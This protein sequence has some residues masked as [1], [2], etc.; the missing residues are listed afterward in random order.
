MD[1]S[2]RAVCI[3]LDVDAV[4]VLVRHGRH[5]TLLSHHT[6]VDTQPHIACQPLNTTFN[7]NTG[8]MV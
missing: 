6:H 3:H 2:L 8:G 5:L 1:I 4:D 7:V